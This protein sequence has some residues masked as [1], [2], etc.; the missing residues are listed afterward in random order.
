MMMMMM[1]M[2][3]CQFRVGSNS[4]PR[5]FAQTVAVTTLISSKCYGRFKI[6]RPPKCNHGNCRSLHP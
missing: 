3:L 4:N 1:I 5:K 6:G 2:V